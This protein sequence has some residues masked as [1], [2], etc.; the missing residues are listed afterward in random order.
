MPCGFLLLILQTLTYPQAEDGEDQWGIA[1]PKLTRDQWA[2]VRA[3]REATGASFPELAAKWGVSHQAIQK[4][5][6]AEGWADGQDVGDTIRK[7]VAE[8]VAGLVAGCNPKM[9]ADAIDAAA[10]RGAAVLSQHQNEWAEHRDRF[11]SVPDDFEQGK[12]AK[13]SAEMLKIRQ[14]GER[15]AHGLDEAVSMPE[16]RI[17]R[18]FGK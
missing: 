5:A 4:R 12:L 17:E 9:K 16:I 18:S 3:E 7:K 10:E 15:L 14:S 13:I 6:K 1:M 11:G 2:D 8:K